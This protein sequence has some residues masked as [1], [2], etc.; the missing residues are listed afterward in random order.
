MRFLTVTFFAVYAN[1]YST[2]SLNKATVFF[3]S[4]V[5]RFGANLREKKLH[6]RMQ[7]LFLNIHTTK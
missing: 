6:V 1:F 2:K 3:C 4:I 5:F 7:Q